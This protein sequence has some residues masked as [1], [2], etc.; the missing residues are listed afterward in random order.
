MSNVTKTKKST[1]VKRKNTVAKTNVTSDELLE[2][3]LNKSKVKKEK[4]KTYNSNNKKEKNFQTYIRPNKKIVTDDSEELLNKILEK[5][6]AKK[7]KPVVKPAKEEVV[8]KVVEEVPEKEE[9]AR[10]VVEP[11]P[12]EEKISEEVVTEAEEQEE[13]EPEDLIITKQIVIDV[14]KLDIKDKKVIEKIKEAV[15]QEQASD[16]TFV[17]KT[18]QLDL[19]ETEEE[20]IIQ[21][22]HPQILDKL[23]YLIPVF[24]LVVSLGTIFVYLFLKNG[25]LS[26]PVENINDLEEVKEIEIDNSEDERLYN[27]CLARPYSEADE[28]EVMQMARAELNSYLAK[29]KTSVEYHDLSVG[30]AYNYNPDKVYYAASVMKSLAAIYIYTKAAVGEMDLNYELTYTSKFN[31]SDSLEMKNHKYGDKITLRELVKYAITVSDNSAYQM[32]VNYIGRQNLKNFGLSLGAKYTLSG[33]D[34][35]GSI[36]VGDAMVYLNALNN[37]INSNGELGEEL[38]QIFLGALQNDIAVPEY[39]VVAAHKYGEY[40][41]NYHDIGI[42]YD[43][44]P[45]LIAVL[46]TEGYGDFEGKIKDI[47]KKVYR[48]HNIFWENRKGI[49]NEEVYLNK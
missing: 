15:E 47:S 32:L 6:K 22:R 8:E 5:K 17:D 13:K 34:N 21:P 12:E 35:F 48:L 4:R 25:G 20:P 2:S 31:W 30:F 42:V 40:K 16:E 46:S 36:T 24:I 1:N 41:P 29:Y 26:S 19:I 37:F 33:G 23:I 9:T 44:K 18:G 43:E 10:E 3:I 49:C 39:G 28:T 7:K 45:Y 11:T 27:E 14:N 38:R